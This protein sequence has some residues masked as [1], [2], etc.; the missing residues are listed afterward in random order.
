MANVTENYGLI[1]PIPEEFYDI[2]VHNSNMDKI[3]TALKENIGSLATKENKSIT[4]TTTLP[5]SSWI[6]DGD[7]FHQTVTVNEVTAN[8]ETCH[9]HV[10]AAPDVFVAWCA[11]QCRATVQGDGTLTFV[12]NSA[13][14]VDL[15]ANL[16]ITNQGV[17][18]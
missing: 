10:S 3:D 16:R 2:G 15:V 7:I 18:R 14:D 12:C 4:T 8:E 11:A 6:K 9:I 1:K 5:V 13:P 17:A